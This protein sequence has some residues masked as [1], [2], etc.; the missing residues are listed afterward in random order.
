MERV[1]QAWLD[2]YRQTTDQATGWL[3]DSR[4]Q[5]LAHFTQD[6]L[7]HRRNEAWKY[8]SLVGHPAIALSP[9]RQSGAVSA[10][11]LA[12]LA[13]NP[14]YHVLL[15]DG[16]YR[17]EYTVLPH[18]AGITAGSLA[19]AIQTNDV[20]NLGQIGNPRDMAALNLAGWQD[21]FF[22]SLAPGIALDHPI[23]VIHLATSAHLSQSRSL[24]QLGENARCEIIEHFVG[25]EAHLLNTATEIHAAANSQIDH[26]QLFESKPNALQIAD[27]GVAQQ[28][29]SR[30]HSHVLAVGEGATRNQITA[31]MNG[32]NAECDLSGLSVLSGKAH[33]DHHTRVEHNVPNCTSQEFYKGIIDDQAKAIFTGRVLVA[34]DAQQTRARQATHNLLL[35]PQ[36]EADARPQLEI[37]ADDVQC[38]HGATVGQLDE[39]ALFYL[40]SRGV[41]EKTAR[42]LLIYG[43]AEEVL[44]RIPNETLRE[45]FQTR[46]MERLPGGEASQWL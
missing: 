21:G 46:M 32:E 27:I 15:V 5:G 26:Y 28:S 45:P 35:S 30:F 41:H 44:D 13:W 19:E 17:P 39:T 9:A 8:S 25:K 1:P 42:N 11:D 18:G 20:A 34:R 38:S 2:H 31:R 4:A 6:G 3:R 12:N 10:E 36:A 7:P 24:I 29:G 14:G 37:Y 22:L 23:Q 16:F 33:A 43:F 40:R